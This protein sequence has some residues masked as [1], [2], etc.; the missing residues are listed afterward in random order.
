M[1]PVVDHFV[2]LRMKGTRQRESNLTGSKVPL[3]LTGWDS[4]DLNMK[5]IGK[6][7]GLIEREADLHLLHHSDERELALEGKFLLFPQVTI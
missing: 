6:L 7:P 1:F 2:L 4:G 5:V 3:Y